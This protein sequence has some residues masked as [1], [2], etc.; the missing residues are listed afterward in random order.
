[1]WPQHAQEIHP[2]QLHELS[3]EELTGTRPSHRGTL[4][5]LKQRGIPADSI[6]FA[7]IGPHR[8]PLKNL[9][10]AI[11]H[12]FYTGPVTRHPEVQ[13][14]F[15]RNLRLRAKEVIGPSQRQLNK[16]YHPGRAMS[17]RELMTG[18]R[19]GRAATLFQRMKDRSDQYVVDESTVPAPHHDPY[20][21]GY[22]E[23][24]RPWQR[25]PWEAAAEHPLGLPDDAFH[26]PIPKAKPKPKL[27]NPVAVKQRGPPGYNEVDSIRQRQQG[28]RQTNTKPVK[29]GCTWKR[30]S[31]N[32]RFHG[33]VQPYMNYN[34]AAKGWNPNQFQSDAE[35]SYSDQSNEYDEADS[36]SGGRGDPRSPKKIGPQGGFS[37]F[38]TRPK[39]WQQHEDDYRTPLQERQGNHHQGRPRAND[40]ARSRQM[41]RNV[42]GPKTRRDESD[43]L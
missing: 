8:G 42:V 36:W 18:R 33:G 40:V 22:A 11:E 28:P 23:R 39:S 41:V 43:D 38:N 4:M 25:S 35:A 10:R 7:E 2:I 14:P 27:Q 5:Y 37:D 15:G 6:H 29:I 9:V 34:R 24:G 26:P 13:P 32:T 31:D 16:G 20:D 19:D 1:M 12:D 21:Q 17:S 30:G 3:L